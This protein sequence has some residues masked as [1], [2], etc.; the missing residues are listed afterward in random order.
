MKALAILAILA[1]S[2]C[3]IP[4]NFAVD[5]Q[6][7]EGVVLGGAYSSKGGIEINVSK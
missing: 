3:G 6:T 2:S 7:P 5:Y 1:L 4:L